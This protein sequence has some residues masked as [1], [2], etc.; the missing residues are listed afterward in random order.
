MT[1][2]PS[3]KVRRISSS[4]RGE[5]HLSWP[6][7]LTTSMRGRCPPAT[8][9]GMSMRSTRPRSIMFQASM[10]GVAEPMMKLTPAISQRFWATCLA[11]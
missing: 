11:W 1:E 4:S 8:R 9:W 7:M 5:M 3:S 6:S 2:R 10:E